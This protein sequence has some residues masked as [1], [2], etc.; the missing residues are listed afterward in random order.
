MGLKRKDLQA[1][2]VKRRALSRNQVAVKEARRKARLESADERI[3]QE[4]VDAEQWARRNPLPKLPPA[5]KIRIDIPGMPS[6]V[7]RLRRWDTGQILVG[8]RITTAKQFGRRI[9]VLLDQF[10]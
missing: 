1:R 4:I 3:Q 7:I 10:L 6:K 5:A 2:A 8:G 9:G